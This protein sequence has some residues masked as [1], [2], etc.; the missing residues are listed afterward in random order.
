[1]K[2]PFPGGRAIVKKTFD[3]GH[4]RYL[5]VY[6]CDMDR[7][8]WTCDMHQSLAEADQHW[9]PIFGHVPCIDAAEFERFTGVNQ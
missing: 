2:T 5:R 3:N 7:Q 9:S 6:W 8:W 4:V 1:M